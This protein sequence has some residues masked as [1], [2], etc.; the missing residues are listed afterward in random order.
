MERINKQKIVCLLLTLLFHST[1]FAMVKE[2][3]HHNA[4]FD[5]SRVIEAIIKVESNGNPRAVSG[6]S[7]G[8]MQITPIAVAECN[9]ILKSRNSKKR[10]K[11]SD[12]YNVEKSKEMFRL[13][14][15]HH[16]PTNNIEKAIRSWNGGI[17][18]SV[19]STQRYY[20]KVMAV[21]NKLRGD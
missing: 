18:Y 1:I 15:S 19:R 17:R 8:V 20:K 6:N 21:M 7:V 9:Q 2:D 10:F 11:L 13:I 16:N 14:Q 12:R 5:W 4:H 3:S